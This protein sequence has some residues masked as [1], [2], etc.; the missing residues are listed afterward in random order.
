MNQQNGAAAG[1]YKDVANLFL[2]VEVLKAITETMK[3]NVVL[4]PQ[5]MRFR[6]LLGV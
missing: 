2:S 4:E 5:R 6:H 1:D 3:P